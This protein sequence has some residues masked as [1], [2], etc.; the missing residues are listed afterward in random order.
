MNSYNFIACKSSTTLSAAKSKALGLD[1]F[2]FLKIWISKV[3][4]LGQTDL[5]SLFKLIAESLMSRILI[6]KRM[7]IRSGGEASSCFMTSLRD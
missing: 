6:Q 5:K 7:R 2:P 4:R 1:P 3:I